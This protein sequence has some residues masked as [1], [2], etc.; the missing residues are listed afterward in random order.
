[1]TIFP[2]RRKCRHP[3]PFLALAMLLVLSGCVSRPKDQ[4]SP[5][6]LLIL[7][8]EDLK[9]ERFEQARA[10]FKRLLRE[11]PDSKHRRVALLNLADSF[12][13]TEE[14]IE[15]KVQYAEFVQLYPI[16]TQTPKAYYFLAMSD[17]NLALSYDRD[18]SASIE[19]LKNFEILIKRFPK[20]EHVAD[21]KKKKVALL[22]KIGRHELFIAR[23]FFNRGQRQSAIPR[24]REVIRKYHDA[25]EVRA[26]A[27]YYLGESYR[28]E[29]SFKKSTEAFRNLITQY[30]SSSFAQ[31]AYDILLTLAKRK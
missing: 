25:P 5:G 6:E 21:A 20:S 29:E 24:L 2:A 13:K 31:R 12:Y 7:G 1:M 17:Y 9:A 27:M 28:Q 11:F 14:Y 23:F 18:Q 15:A 26:E 10:A 19:A 8:Q 16:S 22:K 3:L 4:A 30:P